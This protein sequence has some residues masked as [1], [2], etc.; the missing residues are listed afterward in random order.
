MLRSL[1]LLWILALGCAGTSQ[2]A[3]PADIA[4]LDLLDLLFMGNSHTSFH[5]LPEMVAAMV[6]AVRPGQRVEA[7]T[8]PGWM[9]LEERARDP[10]SVRLLGERSWDVVV[11]QAQKYSTT[12]KYN[13]STAGA[14]SLIR[15]AR[16]AHAVPILFPEWPRHGVAET[17]RIYDLHVGIAAREPACVAP[18]GQAWDLAR[19][20]YP[21]LVLHADDGNH[22]TRAGAYLTALVL[23]ATITAT[24]PAELD[25]QL[26]QFGVPFDVQVRLRSIAARAVLAA[27]TRTGCP[28]DAHSRI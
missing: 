8:A 27:P 7:T 13:Y 26:P 6:R 25:V 3:A 17:D 1:A 15:S 11:L 23:A 4:Q 9:F 14:E 19:A 2:Q 28:A 20:V 16:A 10:A 22:S 12:G 18:I 5:D 21:D 24:S